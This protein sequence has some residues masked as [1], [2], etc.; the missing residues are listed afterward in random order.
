[1]IFGLLLIFL[2]IVFML[3][4]MDWIDAD[5]VLR[6]WPLIIIAGGV[7]KILRPGSSSSWVTGLL[8]TAVGVWLQLNI[9]GYVPF[10]FWD[11]WPLV[12]VLIGA[13]LV[14]RGMEGK[15]RSVATDSASTVNAVAVMGGVTR[16]SNAPDFSGGDLVAFMG[17][18]EV[19]LS[20]ARI[21]QGLAVVDA[22][23]FWGG[24]EIRVP[25]EWTVIVQGVPFLGAFEDSTRPQAV[26]S[27][28]KVRQELVVKGF[29][30]MGGV[31]IKN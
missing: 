2:G 19:D 28:Y 23:A 20:Q 22:F 25:E 24:I 9:L 26:D 3:E 11:F 18:C 16:N 1:M 4:R 10:S 5:N 27:Q 17:G 7:S 15:R 6:F 12:L 31:E 13:R 14:W 8:I 30:I 21:E 29:A